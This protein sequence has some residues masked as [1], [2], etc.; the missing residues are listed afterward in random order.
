MVIGCLNVSG[1]F[2]QEYGLAC[3]SAR[4]RPCPNFMGAV[5]SEFKGIFLKISITV[6]LSIATLFTISAHDL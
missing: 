2:L 4:V 6:Y 3:L 5:R 1:W